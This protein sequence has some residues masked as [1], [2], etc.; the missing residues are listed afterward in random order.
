MAKAK[1]AHA[2]ELELKKMIERR[3]GAEFELWLMPQVRATAANMVMIDKVH[4][5]LTADNAELVT[6]VAGSTGQYKNEVNPLMPYYLKLLAEL[7]LQFEALGLNYR[8]TPKKIT[9]PTKPG[10]GTGNKLI[11]LMEDIKDNT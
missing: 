6:M 5:E 11:E 8:T 3:T 4:K 2:Y 7:R 9:E 1:T 10:G